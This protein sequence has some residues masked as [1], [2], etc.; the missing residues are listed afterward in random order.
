MLSVL[1]AP[2]ASQYPDAV[3][4][5]DSG[6]IGGAGN[7]QPRSAQHGDQTFSIGAMTLDPARKSSAA[8]AATGT[9]RRR[10]I[11]TGAAAG[12]GA[13]KE[14]KSVGVYWEPVS[15]GILDH[16]PEVKATQKTEKY[17]CKHFEI[18][19]LAW[20]LHDVYATGSQ[21]LLHCWCRA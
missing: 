15:P 16:S 14:K 2:D 19:Q 11:D 3:E 6:P 7:F 9:E 1:S 8:A 13:A 12:A 10:S 5:G 21:M 4:I 18:A 17:Y 20:G